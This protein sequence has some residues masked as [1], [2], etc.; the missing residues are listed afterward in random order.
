MRF[1]ENTF[2]A[3]LAVKLVNLYKQWNVDIIYNIKILSLK[4]VMTTNKDVFFKKTAG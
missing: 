3:M 1:V 2:Y 4:L